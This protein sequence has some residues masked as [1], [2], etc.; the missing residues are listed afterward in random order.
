[1]SAQDEILRSWTRCL[2]EDLLPGLHGH[3]VKAVA[4]LSLGMALARHCCGSIVSL[5]VPARGAKPASVRRQQERLLANRRLSPQR[6]MEQMSRHLLSNWSAPRLLLI[7]DETPKGDDL[8]VLKLSAAFHKREVALAAVCYRNGALPEPMPRLV[9]GLLRRAGRLLS[10]VANPNLRVTL[11]ADRGLCWPVVVQLCRQLGWHWVLRAQ[12][13][14]RLRLADGS[15]R[16]LGELVR[17]PGD[18]WTGSGKVFKKSGWTSA[19]VVACWPEG[20]KEPWLLVTDGHA[21]FRCCRS[22]CTRTWCEES[23]RDHKS[24]GLQWQQSRVHDPGHAAQ[25]FLLIVLAVL[26]AIALGRQMIKRGRRRDLDP[27]RQ[28]RLSVFQLGDRWLLA[29]V[30]RQIPVTVRFSLPP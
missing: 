4:R 8:R 14:T 29:C 6:A 30:Y 5:A 24:G 9:A 22:Y 27:H 26:L 23:H 20:G 1:M 13:A 28:R 10:R 11:L 18:Q 12:H 19:D 7:L 3:Q 16:S 15:E 25:L 21:S 17:R 2:K